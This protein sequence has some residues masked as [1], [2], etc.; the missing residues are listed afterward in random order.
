MYK[1]SGY[2]RKYWLPFTCKIG[3]VKEAMYYIR[4]DGF[5]S[6]L[7]V[8]HVFCDDLISCLSNPLN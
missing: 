4:N 5:K 2:T 1:Y 3:D 6:S 8:F 7:I